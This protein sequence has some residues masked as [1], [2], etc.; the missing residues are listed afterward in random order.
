M[1]NVAL[2]LVVVTLNFGLW[3][4]DSCASV[5]LDFG[6][7]TSD[8]SGLTLDHN[9]SAR[10]G[11]KGCSNIKKSRNTERGLISHVIASV[12]NTMS[13]EMAVLKRRL[14]RSSVTFLMHACSALSCA[15]DGSA[16]LM[17]WFN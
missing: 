16:S 8:S 4:L 14:S 13:A 3:A 6:L 15:G 11:A 2:P 12:T 10:C 17:A 1:S 5:T 9:S 7:W